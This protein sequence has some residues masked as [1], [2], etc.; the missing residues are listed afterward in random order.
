MGT[1]TVC[2]KLGAATMISDKM[3]ATARIRVTVS[4]GGSSITGC[5]NTT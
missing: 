5:Y 1:L 4:G 3:T 2:P